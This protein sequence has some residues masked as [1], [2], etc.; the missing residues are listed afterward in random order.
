[1]QWTV[2]CSRWERMTTETFLGAE[3]QQAWPLV[4][5]A[6]LL[7]AVASCSTNG[8]KV[9]DAS[10]DGRAVDSDDARMDVD[11]DA[12]R[13]VA[14]GVGS[15]CVRESDCGDTT[16]LGC[17]LSTAI[18]GTCQPCGGPSQI[19]CNTVTCRDG[20]T[21]LLTPDIPRYCSAAPLPSPDGGSD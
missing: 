3:R 20:L 9:V 4:K 18:M 14:P 10:S 17:N 19:C 21:C 2:F 12:A 5:T 8:S 16:V 7:I 6:L 13:E 1:V 11:Q 15:A